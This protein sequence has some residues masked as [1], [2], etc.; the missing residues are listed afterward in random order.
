[1][2]IDKIKLELPSQ[3]ADICRFSFDFSNLMKTIEYL[4]NNNLI[5]IKEIKNLRT[6]VFDLEILRT[7]FDKI[8]ENSKIIEKSH[9]NLNISFLSMKEKFIQNDSNMTDLIK[10]NE[11]KEKDFDKY[12]KIIEGH[13]TNINNLNK[14][15]EENV[16]NIKQNHENLVLNFDRINKCE[17]ELKQINSDNIK[18]N[19]LIQKNDNNTKN[20]NEKNE[21]SIESLNNTIAEI[22][23]TINSMKIL[24]DK[25]NRDFDLCINNIMDNISE[26][27]TKGVKTDIK[28]KE[29]NDNNLFKIAMGEIERINEKINSN[30]EEQKI[31]MDKKDKESDM[32]K[33]LIEGLQ[34]DINNINNKIVDLN[35]INTVSVEEEKNLK[36]NKLETENINNSYNKYAT[37]KSVE[38]L[39]ENLK[40]LMKSFATLPNRDEYISSQRD[41]IARIK[42]LEDSGMG[43]MSF[44]SKINK[45]ENNKEKS[46]TNVNYF[47]PTFAEKLRI[48]LMS[49]LTSN[50]REM[51]KKE[52]KNIDLTKNSQILELLKLISKHSE[53]INNNNKSVIDL[54]KTLIAI[55]IDKRINNIL[56][57]IYSLDEDNERCKKKILVLNQI[58]NGYNEKDDLDEN[59]ESFEP[60]CLR[61]KIEINE[62]LVHNMSEKVS[63]IESKYKSITKEIKDDI[64]SNLKV[65]SIK[66]LSQFREKLELFTRRFEEELRNK[67][68]QMGLNNFE[69]KMNT[70]LYYDL[71]D[72]LNRQ[73]M[74]KN[75]NLI[76]RKIDSLENKISKTLVDTII[77]LQMD[78]APLII[79]KAPNNIEVCASCNQIIQKEKENKS[80]TNNNESMSPNHLNNNNNNKSLNSLSINKFMNNSTNNKFR[81][82]FYGFNKTQTSMPKINNVM[83]L[84]KELPDINKY[85]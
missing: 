30:N 24:M 38:K 65:E 34:S 23:Q 81:K 55:D 19:E 56:E 11:Q 71:K 7:E 85:N 70:K 39:N 48:S 77:D 46:E 52:G 51:I 42:K 69:K 41:I 1:M 49:D 83:S 20:E 10:K 47:N 4:F 75:N 79:K 13:D 53:E 82:T 44:D 16:K 61:G 15:V 2:D 73:E 64:K 54:R 29:N 22:K 9:E 50:F 31:L 32:I 37:Q 28:T 63:S 25:K 62:Q 80:L 14:V 36:Q 74:Q 78:E 67:I 68:D 76:N 35:T 12:I 84:K 59:G 58:I 3:L 45:L 27:N 17:I 72:K 43:M 6:R 66:T 21:K 8:K 5:M 33:R 40:Q 26:L 57:K 60:T 18:T